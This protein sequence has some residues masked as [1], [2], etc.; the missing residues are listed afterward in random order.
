MEL[1]RRKFIT[2]L[3]AGVGCVMTANTYSQPLPYP[4]RPIRF[5]VGYPPG[6]AGD[7]VAR[8]VSSVMATTL[9][10]A[11]IIDNKPGAG[12]ILSAVQAL[13]APADGYTLLLAGS[14]L[15]TNNPSIRNK[16]PYDSES[17]APIGTIC[18][19]PLV[20]M[21]SPKSGITSLEALI[22]QAKAEPA[23]LNFGSHGL[24]STPHFAGEMLNNAAGIEITHVPFNGS[25]PNMTALLGDQ[26][27]LAID[28][29][30]AAG[31]HIKSGKIK[32]LAVFSS[33]KLPEL[34]DVKTV[35]EMGY[36]EVNLDAWI[37]IHVKRD[38]PQAI[39]E[40]LTLAL[41]NAMREMEV[42][43]R[44]ANMGLRP[45]FEPPEVVDARVEREIKLMRGIATQ[46]NITVS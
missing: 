45:T 22:R 33:E 14:T 31:P 34:P 7:S 4:N 39:R 1:T 29:L 3:I 12:A 26:I 2:Q 5:I 9:G 15:L 44:I 35:A 27:P 17:F 21:A 46:S 6:G 18:T 41:S 43:E 8:A 19:M 16:L 42:R 30:A 13:N 11:V 24:G 20:L 10:Q 23:T 38:T 37:T 36:P 32:A 25:A 28:S 40:R